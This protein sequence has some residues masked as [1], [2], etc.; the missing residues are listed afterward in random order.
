MFT[1][2]L[3]KIAL[4]TKGVPKGL[5]R[6]NSTALNG[7]AY[8]ITIVLLKKSLKC[9]ERVLLRVFSHFLTLLRLF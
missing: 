2:G 3:L 8:V 6:V 7:Y 5:L 1:V 4:F 9:I